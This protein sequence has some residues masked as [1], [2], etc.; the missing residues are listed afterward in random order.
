[1]PQNNQQL[2]ATYSDLI[3]GTTPGFVAG[4]TRVFSPQETGIRL[5]KMPV[6]AAPPGISFTLQLPGDPS[7]GDNYGFADVDGSVDANHGLLV[8]PTAPAT[9][10]GLTAQPFISEFAGGS[11]EYDSGR[12]LW[13]FS[14]AGVSSAFK[15]FSGVGTGFANPAGSVVPGN[16]PASAGGGRTLFAFELSPRFSVWHVDFALRFSIAGADTF[17]LGLASAA[18]LTSIVGG[19]QILGGGGL[20]LNYETG[21]VFPVVTT[22]S[23]PVLVYPWERIYAG[24]TTDSM[25][26]SGDISITPTTIAGVS[27]PST[28]FC[29]IITVG[30]TA[31]T[32]LTLT[33]NAYALQ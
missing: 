17:E 16:V 18:G 3:G 25:S 22:T 1:M 7:D 14:D 21:G 29:T 26:W 30:A 8:V 20:S 31:V 24:A 10:L 5:S 6:A 4:G 12:N 11:Y 9:I 23:L 2:I 33:A 15:S 32:A 19:T 27:Q 13:V 28:V